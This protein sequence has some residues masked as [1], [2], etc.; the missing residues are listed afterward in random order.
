MGALTAHQQ[1]GERLGARGPLLTKDVSRLFERLRRTSRSVL[2]VLA[3]FGLVM[4]PA[5][6]APAEP[7]VVSVSVTGN[8]HVPTD[9]ILAVLSTKVGDPFDPAKVQADLRAIADLGFNIEF[10]VL[11]FPTC[12]RKAALEPDD[13]ATIV[14]TA[15]AMIG[16]SGNVGASAFASAGDSS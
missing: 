7:T 12:Q 16:A 6:A 2:A 5:H 1:P 14:R 10:E 8:A 11:D 13:A 15:H 4:P 9:R 3:F